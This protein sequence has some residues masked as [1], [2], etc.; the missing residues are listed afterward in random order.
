MS[1]PVRQVI[2]DL[3]NGRLEEIESLMKDGDVETRKDLFNYALTLLSWAM[4]EVRNGRVIV[5][6]N[7]E[8]QGYE[9]VCIPP[10]ENAA[11]KVVAGLLPDCSHKGRQ[12]N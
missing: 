12:L 8:T 2:F 10:L 7:E 5:S 1:E 9:R 11:K 6:L 3:N 4:R